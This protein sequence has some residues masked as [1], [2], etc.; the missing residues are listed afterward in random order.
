MHFKVFQ[1]SV[2]LQ[3][4]WQNGDAF[5]LAVWALLIAGGPSNTSNGGAF[6]GK[7]V[8][9]EGHAG[10]AEDRSDRVESKKRSRL[11]RAVCN[12]PGNGRAFMRTAGGR[13]SR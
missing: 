2:S 7:Q 8:R 13:G 1:R 12:S 6:E 4:Q 11:G 9:G 5:K 10:M 3:P